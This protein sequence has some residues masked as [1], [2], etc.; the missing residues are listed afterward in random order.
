MTEIDLDSFDR[1]I[2]RLLQVD[3]RIS[4]QDLAEKVGLSPPACLRRVRSLRESGVILN[5]VS[6]LDPRKVGSSLW[7]LVLIEC[8]R[9]RADLVNEMKRMFL[10]QREILQCFVVTGP[11]DF[12]VLVVSDDVEHYEVF[13]DRVFRSNQ[14][15]RRFETMVVMSRV[16]MS[17][18]LPL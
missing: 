14:N 2:L 16:K 12:A 13:A 3:N 15:I 4:N 11:A 17:L 8:E 10:K 1:N 7:T 18:E 5:D 9:E 6:V